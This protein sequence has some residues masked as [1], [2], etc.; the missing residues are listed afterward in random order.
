[1]IKMKTKSILSIVILL[2]F[3]STKAVTG[4]TSPFSGEWKLNRTKTV[5]Q[6]SR[7]FLSQI[8]INLKSDSLLTTRVYQSDSGEEY[9]FVENLSLDGKDCKIIIYD[10][11]RTSKASFSAKTGLI[12]VESTTTFYGDN[13]EDNLKAKETWKVEEK[14]N[15]LTFLT[16][17]TSSAGSSADTLYFDRVK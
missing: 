3:F 9:P 8:K 7:L 5:L 11:P 13:G 17:G 1:M 2:V 14:G 16:S 4:Q 6:S 12:N 10:M 15:V